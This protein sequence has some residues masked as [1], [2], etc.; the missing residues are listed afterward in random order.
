MPTTYTCDTCG[1]TASS[2]EGW[3]PVA[4]SF[5]YRGVPDLLFHTLACRRA[6]CEKAGIVDPGD[7]PAPY[8]PMSLTRIEPTLPLDV[9][10]SIATA[11]HG[12]K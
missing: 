9:A 2:A 8:T 12:T 5:G 6:W 4:V 10:E 7:R 3:Y 11:I 1:Q